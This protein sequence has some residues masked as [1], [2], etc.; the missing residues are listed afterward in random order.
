M[1]KRTV[2]QWT[3]KQY[4]GNVQPWSHW[5]LVFVALKLAGVL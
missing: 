1:S 3:R 4:S 2:R 5:S